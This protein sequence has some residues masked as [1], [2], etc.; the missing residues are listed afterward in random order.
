VK[1]VDPKVLAGMAAIEQD[2]LGKRNDFELSFTFLLASFP[3]VAKNVKAKGLGENVS[4]H[5][6]KVVVKAGEEVTKGTTGVE[7]VGMSPASSSYSPKSKKLSLQLVTSLIQRR[8][9]T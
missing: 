8:T 2:K 7:L 1:T 9:V 4:G 6:G 3:V 5:D